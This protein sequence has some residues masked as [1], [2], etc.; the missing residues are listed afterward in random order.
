MTRSFPPFKCGTLLWVLTV[1]SLA[2][3]GAKTLPS[4][5]PPHG[6]YAVV[7]SAATAERPEWRK[8]AQLLV[9]K[10]AG[11][12]IIYP[13]SVWQSKEALAALHPR[14]ACFVARPGEA[15]RDF[16]VAVS[17]LTRQLDSDPY[18]DV[19]WGILTGYDAA[20]ARRIA[21]RRVPLVVRRGLG[22]TGALNLS[23]FEAGVKFNEG[24]AGGRWI[25]RPGRRERREPWA[26]DSTRGL[27][28]AFNYYRPDL[29]MTSGHA[30]TRDW[31][32]GYSYR[33][34]QF[35]CRDGQLYALDTRGRRY[36][37]HSPNPKVYLPTGNCLIG[38]IPVRDCMAL[39]FM[40][41]AG[42]YQ[43]IGYTV[44]T[45][46]GYMGWG[47]SDYFI[48]QHGCYSLAQAFFAANQALVRRLVTEFPEKAGLHFA[49]YDNDAPGRLAKKYELRGRD[50]VGLL[51]DRDTVA[52]YG[53]PAWQARFPAAGRP[54]EYTLA[55]TEGRFRL[56][57]T[58]KRDGK[59]GSRPVV[60]LLP[61][62]VQHVA[63]VSAPDADHPVVTDDF[64]LLPL[65]G[66]FKKGQRFTLTFRAA[67][68]RRRPQPQPDSTTEAV[69]RHYPRNQRQDLLQTLANAGDNRPQLLAA[70]RRA[71][72][73][74]RRALGYLVANMPVVDA[75]TLTAGFLLRNVASALAARNQ[76]AW[77]SKVPE[78]V[79]LDAVVPYASL[80]E[81]RDDWR[82][83][84]FKRFAASVRDCQTPGAAA[85]RLNT[86]IFAVLNVRYHATKRPK[87]DQSPYESME[88]HY[89]SCTGLSLLL[90][91][92]CRAVGV[93]ARIVGV[94]AWTGKRG[95]HTWVEVWDN[96]DWHFLGAAESTRLD[97][98]W[99]TTVAAKADLHDPRHHIYASSWRRTTLH[100]PLVWDPTIDWVNA[101]DVS[102][103]YV[104]RKR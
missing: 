61:F 90:V 88:A 59:W 29:F 102:D 4:R 99:F 101:V 96:G 3:A 52:F 12:E 37:I 103:R 54:W 10:Y 11:N 91:D 1:C 5:V 20:D 72:P 78:D 34:G 70:L 74:Q 63:N 23:V 50:E 28:D 82:E 97:S 94:P 56:Q 76:T 40:H 22:G 32:I 9:A 30:T 15:N 55:E 51:W 66:P 33:D 65:K 87:P 58:A 14:Y 69:L 25:K 19:L 81:R 68:A 92:A 49:T 62:R 31:Q 60:V 45:F 16:V 43:M 79:F 47:V 98:A 57:L 95:N 17:R 24:V 36:D 77:G 6:S 67:R 89:A 18:G 80:N 48:G 7:L 21:A 83:D 46:Y 39:A 93:P 38:Q 27:V 71:T 100:F 42:V 13:S 86:S 104:G 44:V 53:D 2:P 85:V 26:K 84:F 35:R 41:S 64:V 73:E 75:R 8:V